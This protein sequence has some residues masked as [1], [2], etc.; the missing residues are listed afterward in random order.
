M[1]ADVQPDSPCLTM[2]RLNGGRQRLGKEEHSSLSAGHKGLLQGHIE[3]RELDTARS[4]H[5]SAGPCGTSP[6]VSHDEHSRMRSV[7]RDIGLSSLDWLPEVWPPLW[8][9]CPHCRG[10][11]WQEQFWLC[12]FGEVGPAVLSGLGKSPVGGGTHGEIPGTLGFPVNLQCC[13]KAPSSREHAREA[14]AAF[15]CAPATISSSQ[16]RG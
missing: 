4:P 9:L 1:L 3:T 11:T 7:L 10:R 12:G 5:S 13:L 16:E 14:R 8:L 2:C 6:G 15:L